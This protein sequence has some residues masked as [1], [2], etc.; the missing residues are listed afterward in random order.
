MC[1]MR[2]EIGKSRIVY[3]DIQISEYAMRIE[4][5]YLHILFIFEYAQIPPKN[6]KMIFG[7]GK[8][9]RTF[10]L[11]KYMCALLNESA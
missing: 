4:K 11:F 1:I 6:P 10:G 3:A 8:Y 9:M 7:L 2:L 5:M